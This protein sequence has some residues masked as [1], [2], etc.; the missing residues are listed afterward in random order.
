METDKIKSYFF[1]KNPVLIYMEFFLDE[2]T[3]KFMYKLII[4]NF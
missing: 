4:E 1:Y 3:T 2:E